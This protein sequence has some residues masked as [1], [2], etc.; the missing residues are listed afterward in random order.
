MKLKIKSNKF[1]ILAVVVL[2]A[3]VAIPSMLAAKPMDTKADEVDGEPTFDIAPIHQVT[4]ND[5]GGAYGTHAQQSYVEDGVQYYRNGDIIEVSIMLPKGHGATVFQDVVKYD[6]EKLTLISPFTDI[7]ATLSKNYLDKRWST[8][9]SNP[10]ADTSRI[11]VFGSAADFTTGAEYQGGSV[12]R[13]YFRVNNNVESDAGTAITFEFPE[14]QTAGYSNGKVVYTHRGYDAN[15]DAATAFY[16]AEPVTIYAKT[17]SK[18]VNAPTLNLKNSSATIYEGDLFDPASYISNASCEVDKSVSKDT[19]DISEGT[20][21]YTKH[22]P[23]AGTYVYKYSVTSSTGKSTEKQ[24]SLKVTARTY[25]VASIDVDSKK[26]S[27]PVGT[28]SSDLE[29]MINEMKKEDFNVTITC[30]D[31]SKFVVPGKVLNGKTD[32]Y[33]IDENDKLL[34]Q[35]FN[36]NFTLALP[37][38]SYGT[39]GSRIVTPYNGSSSFVSNVGNGRAD[40]KVPV[41]IGTGNSGGN[42]TG[43]N[44]SGKPSTAPTAGSSNGSGSAASTGDTTNVTFL[45]V[46]AILSAG[47]I[48]RS[49]FKKQ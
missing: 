14:F 30:N 12:A 11:L 19:V 43:G 36:V 40:A 37:L 10:N 1:K 47:F 29:A 28:A 33:R 5:G 41:I 27:L 24:L 39:D 26:I 17:P 45:A 6:E 35:T 38:V 9:V 32:T 31:G 21:V 15:N 18:T 44:S 3:I 48:V 25:T 20:G 49:K 23:A 8:E 13:M 34:A 42:N 46:L 16:Q 2:A 22:Q 7:K 4:R